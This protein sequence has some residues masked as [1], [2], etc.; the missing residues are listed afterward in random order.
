MPISGTKMAY[1]GLVHFCATLTAQRTAD[2]VV[3]Q[4]HRATPIEADGLHLARDGL[5][6]VCSGSWVSNPRDLRAAYRNRKY[7]S[8]RDS[9]LGFR[10]VRTSLAGATGTK[11]PVIMSTAG[12]YSGARNRSGKISY[13]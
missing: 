10:L 3:H 8:S 13:D 12:G 1:K 6:I 9:K 11:V 2:S 4:A 5:R 7:T